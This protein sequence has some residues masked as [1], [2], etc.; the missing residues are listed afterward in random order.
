MKRSRHEKELVTSRVVNLFEKQEKNQGGR[1]T[2]NEQH[3][4]SSGNS[5][6]SNGSS[7][8][9]PQT[10]NQKVAQQ[11]TQSQPS[12][13]TV[14]KSRPPIAATSTTKPGDQY[15]TMTSRRRQQTITPS[16]H[17]PR[18]Q[19]LSRNFILMTILHECH[20]SSASLLGIRI[21][22]AR[23]YAR[24]GSIMRQT[25]TESNNCTT[26]PVYGSGATCQSTTT[27]FPEYYIDTIL[28]LIT[29]TL[30]PYQLIHKPLH[31][32]WTTLI[33]TMLLL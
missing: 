31:R 9:T 20:H 33:I 6:M 22:W 14:Q 3:S 4:N 21:L 2:S 5:L 26:I 8:A 15:T 28:H 16:R 23:T 18:E 7:G 27:T 25:L 19:K 1:S 11:Q 29:L 12:Q 30:T 24:R 17:R 10:H 13:S 32:R